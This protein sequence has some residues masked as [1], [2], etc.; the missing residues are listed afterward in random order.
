MNANFSINVSITPSAPKVPMRLSCI[1]SIM[2]AQSRPL[3]KPSQVS[4]RPSICMPPVTSTSHSTI[5]AA[6]AIY[7]PV[8]AYPS[9]PASA[10]SAPT[11]APTNGK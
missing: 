9:Q 6:A 11:T 10:I 2:R 3:K 4:P 1:I 7:E 5:S 8:S